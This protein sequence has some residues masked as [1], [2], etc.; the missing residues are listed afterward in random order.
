[1]P[2]SRPRRHVLACAWL[3][4]TVL[5]AGALPAASQDLRGFALVLA[6]RSIDFYARADKGVRS[7]DA[8][9]AERFLAE[10]RSRL[11]QTRD[12]RRVRYYRVRD[13]A[14]VAAVVGREAEGFTSAGGDRVVALRPCNRHELVHV[15]A[16]ELGDPGRFFQEGLAVALARESGWRG[17]AL[18]RAA[19]PAVARAPLRRFVES[20]DSLPP[21]DAYA[22]AGSFVG[23]L[24]ERHGLGVVAD[25]FRGARV[26]DSHGRWSREGAFQQAFGASLEEAEGAWRS[27]L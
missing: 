2:G 19:R 5:A 18:D 12:A 6:T 20:F 25:F 22:V 14:D 3:L 26:R 13:R 9:A 8:E 24:I 27:S 21:A 11:G 1:M 15:A 10:V 7:G 23:H 4:L 16:L 17:R